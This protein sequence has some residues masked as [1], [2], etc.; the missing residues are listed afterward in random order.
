[1]MV[2]NRNLHF[3]GSFSGSM[4]VF[5]G[6]YKVHLFL[7]SMPGV[8]SWFGNGT[9]SPVNSGDVSLT[10]VG[11]KVRSWATFFWFTRISH[12]PTSIII[13][14]Q[15]TVVMCFFVLILYCFITKLLQNTNQ[16]MICGSLEIPS[17]VLKRVNGMVC[18]QAINLNME[19]HCQFVTTGNPWHG[20]VGLSDSN[21]FCKRWSTA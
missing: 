4:L 21:T 16:L 19:N 5:G 17:F 15:E 20:K 11:R 18:T 1:M 12:H 10:S 9:N 7:N 6:V 2:L 8:Q 14:L 3:Q 13:H